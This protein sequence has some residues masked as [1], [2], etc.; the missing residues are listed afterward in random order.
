MWTRIYIGVLAAAVLVVGFFTYYAWT[1]LESIGKP[2]DA[3]AGYENITAVSW[4]L[5]CVCTAVL[6]F[7]ASGVVWTRGG[8][9][10]LWLTFAY[11]TVFVAIGGFYLD[12]EYKRLLEST[13]GI[14]T[15]V[16][17]TTVISVLMIAG[18]AIPVLA[19]QYL[20]SVMRQ[21]FKRSASS[22]IIDLEAENES[23]RL[24]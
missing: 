18:A 16:W 15:N 5:L 7:I 12:R 23:S 9:W 1:W 21:K 6:L 22:P 14:D 24:M 8:A 4:P 3:I 2:A 20:I 17:A 19:L 13:A 10:A 11:F